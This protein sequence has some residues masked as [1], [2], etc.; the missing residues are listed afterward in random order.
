MLKSHGTLL[1]VASLAACRTASPALQQTTAMEGENGLLAPILFSTGPNL[2]EGCD[3]AWREMMPSQQ[4]T[5]TKRAFFAQCFK[6]S[7][8]A[9]CSDGFIDLASGNEPLCVGHG[10]AEHQFIRVDG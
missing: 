7:F 3:D 6:A 2:R 8:V 4:R 10:A 5:S 1:F 9:K